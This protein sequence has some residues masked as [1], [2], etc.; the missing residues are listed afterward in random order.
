MRIVFLPEMRKVHFGSINPRYSVIGEWDMESAR[1][2]FGSTNPNSSRAGTAYPTMIL[3]LKMQRRWKVFMWNVVLVM[4]CIEFLT[5][6]AFK[7]DIEEGEAANRMGLCMI[8]VLTAIAFLQLVT[9]RLPNLPYLTF[10]DWYIYSSYIF[11]V[12]VMVETAVLHAIYH[13]DESGEFAANETDR[14]FF[15]TCMI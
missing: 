1:I 15:L 13:G 3:R 2:E 6:T 12:A 9:A 4:M 14:V 5:L 10:I 8:M 11:L 7:L